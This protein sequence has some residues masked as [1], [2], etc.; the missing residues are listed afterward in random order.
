M[1]NLSRIDVHQHILPPF[2]VDQLRTRD[3]IRRRWPW[4][5]QSAIEFMDGRNIQTGVVSLPPPALSEWT[6][7]SRPDI[8]RRVND[9]TAEV[10][11]EHRQRFG[12]FATLPLPD[13]DGSLEELTYTFDTLK[14]DGVIVLSNYDDQYPAAVAFE[15]LW[16]ELDRRAA[17]VFIHPTFPAIRELKLTRAPIVD[18]PFDTTRTAVNLVLSGVLSRYPAIKFILSHA[19]GFLP[20]AVDR[21]ASMASEDSGNKVSSEE[22]LAIFRRFYF[23]TALSSSTF[24]LSCLTIFAERSHILYGSDFPYVPTDEHYTPNLDSSMV[25]TQQSKAAIARDNAEVLFP[26]FGSRACRD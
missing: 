16:Q 21:F 6:L 11:R 10:V 18:F 26:R 14:A 2:W 12:F 23:D 17:V 20:Y 24:T 19:G 3:L 8:A 4:S 15:P 25:L 9:Y 13:I 1:T 22:F 5:P 7:A